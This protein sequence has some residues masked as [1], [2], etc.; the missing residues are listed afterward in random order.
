MARILLLD[1]DG[2]FCEELAFALRSLDHHEVLIAHNSRAAIEVGCLFR[3]HV[4]VTEVVVGDFLTGFNVAEALEL[5]FPHLQTVVVT[6]FATADIRADAESQEIFGLIEKPAMISEI[7]EM[8][9]RALNSESKLYDSLPVGVL[10]VD[11]QDTIIYANHCARQMI[12]DQNREERTSRLSQILPPQSVAKLKDE[13]AR[14][15]EVSPFNQD[16]ETWLIRIKTFSD[17]DSRLLVVVREKDA[18]CIYEPLVYNL[19]G[20]RTP[21]V[22][23]LEVDGHLLVIDDYEHGRRVAAGIL[24]EFNCFCHTAQTEA[25][26]WR[27]FERDP[28]IH[29]VI[30]DCEIPQAKAER[31][32]EQIR[33]LRP[34]TNIIV[35]TGSA[36]Q[37]AFSR[38][39]IKNFLPKPW[40]DEDLVKL[41]GKKKFHPF[42]SAKSSGK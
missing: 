23:E 26:G 12:G 19:L 33:R 13:E 1:E 2:A 17:V 14:W 20:T 11:P 39:G 16:D 22:D 30:L 27:L 37:T 42:S 8:V 28:R 4:M 15:F 34:E 36:A 32:V 18:S 40:S 3:P 5:V 9:R 38:L 10:E 6:N 35:S 24:R 7:R 21:A 41:V 25:E 31:L 29:N